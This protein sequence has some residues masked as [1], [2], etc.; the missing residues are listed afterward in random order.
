MGRTKQ[1]TCFFCVFRCLF[2]LIMHNCQFLVFA[3]F[4]SLGSSNRPLPLNLIHPSH[5]MYSPSDE[6]HCLRSF[7]VIIIFIIHV[8]ILFVLVLMQRY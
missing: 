4:Q 7:V 3:I 5:Q 6:L 8:L 1:I 2:S